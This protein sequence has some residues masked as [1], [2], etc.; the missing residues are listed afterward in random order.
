MPRDP[1]ATQ[2]FRRI[3]ELLERHDVDYVVVGGVAA[4]LTDSGPFN[5]LG[6]IGNGKRYEDVAESATVVSIGDLPIKVL[7]VEALLEDKKALGR[8]KDLVAIRLLEA[9]VKR[10]RDR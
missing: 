1:R 2:S 7:S 9:L 3:I 8:H 10:K 5:L 6:M 4:V